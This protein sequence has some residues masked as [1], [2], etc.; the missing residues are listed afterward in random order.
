MT[1]VAIV[2]IP[3]D[4]GA[5]AFLAVAGAKRSQGA[6][7][8]EALDTLTAQLSADE[9]DTLI[10]VR[11]RRPDRYF[12]ADHQRR[13]AEL[14]ARWRSAIEQGQSLSPAEQAE[15]DALVDVELQASA[16]RSADLAEELGR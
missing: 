2:P 15:L 8:G 10:V 13:L 4:A 12:D 7:A 1:K 16:T 3:T 9:A 6:T 11:R 5:T 14:M